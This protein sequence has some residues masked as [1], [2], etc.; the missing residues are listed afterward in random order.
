MSRAFPARS[1]TVGLIWSSAIFMTPIASIL[2]REAVLQQ[3]PQRN[4]AGGPRDFLSL[5]VPPTGVRDRDFV[6]AKRSLE[7]F[8]SELGLDAKA[9]RLERHRPEHFHPQ[10]FVAGLH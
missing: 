8:G 1:P 7:D 9:V 2:L 10:H 5:V 3:D 6:H 4:E